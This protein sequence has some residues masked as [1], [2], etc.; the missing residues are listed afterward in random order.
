MH[1]N[2]T[3]GNAG[4]SKAAQRFYDMVSL[5]LSSSE[6]AIL[7]GGVTVVV[8]AISYM[9]LAR[10]TSAALSKKA[11]RAKA[12]RQAY[13]S[14]EQRSFPS[15]TKKIKVGHPSNLCVRRSARLTSA[16][17]K[18]R[19]H[20]FHADKPGMQFLEKLVSD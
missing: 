1:G 20:R 3:D 13:N 14:M 5:V 15:N 17:G 19:T 9:G 6:I 7:F 4:A 18:H 11:Q 8:A 12:M 16:P 2:F 10:G